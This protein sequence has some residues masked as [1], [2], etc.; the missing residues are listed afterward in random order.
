M[1]YFSPLGKSWSQKS[2]GPVSLGEVALRDVW[3]EEKGGTL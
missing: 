1:F 3:V 2:S